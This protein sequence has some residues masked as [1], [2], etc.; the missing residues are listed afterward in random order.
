MFLIVLVDFLLSVIKKYCRLILSFCAPVLKLTGSLRSLSS[1]SGRCLEII[2]WALGVLI[3]T[4]KDYH[5]IVTWKIVTLSR[6][7]LVDKFNLWLQG[8][9][10][11]QNLTIF[12]GTV[13]FEAIITSCLDYCSS[14][15][16][17]WF[18][19]LLPLPL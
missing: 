10:Y 17:K 18:S 3:V 2:I 1:F 4:L 8:F 6:P 5:L 13:V 7:F 19:L 15:S 11:T 14:L 9:K 16:L 12:I